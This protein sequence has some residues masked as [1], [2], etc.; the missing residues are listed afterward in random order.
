M[1]EE[2]GG[3]THPLPPGQKYLMSAEQL[4]VLLQNFVSSKKYILPITS[5]K[6][7]Y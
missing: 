4:P 1:G 7:Y 6:Y 5:I 3:G 2:G